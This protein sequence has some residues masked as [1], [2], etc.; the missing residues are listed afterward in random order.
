[1]N[2]KTKVVAAFA[3]AAFLLPG[4]SLAQTATATATGLRAEVQSL[5][6]E[7]QSL[8]SQIH[9]NPSRVCPAWGCNGPEPTPVPIR[10]PITIASSSTPTTTPTTTPAL[11]VSIDRSSPPAG[12]IVQNSTGNT[13]G[14][15]DFTNTSNSEG[16]KITQMNVLDAVANSGVKAAFSN[17]SLW[18]G[19]TEL[20]TAS[21][22][23][24][25]AAGTGYLYTFNAFPNAPVVP[26]NNSL[27]LTLRGDAGSYAN[28]SMT[29]GSTLTF[30]IATTTDLNNDTPALAVMAYGAT[31]NV[32]AA[33]TL[34]GADANPQTVLRTVL[35]IA[36]QTVT[37]MPPSSF[38]QLGSV[39]LTANAAGDAVLNSL[40]LTT[41]QTNSAFLSSLVLHDSSG[42]DIVS[43]DGFAQSAVSGNAVT[44]TFSPSAKPLDVA[45]GSAYTLTLW[46]DLSKL[47]AVANVAQ[48]ISVSIQNSTDFSYYD[49]AN[50]TPTLV[51]LGPYQ[52]GPITVVSLQGSGATSTPTSTPITKFPVACP[53][54]MPYCPNGWH[55]VTT[56][57]GCSMRA[58][59]SGS[60][61]IQPGRLQSSAGNT[62]DQTAI[63][64]QSLQT[65]GSEL[66]G[67]LK[68]L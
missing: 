19:S 67:L 21:A 7:V 55:T 63:I 38:Q 33:I 4:I 15:F 9:Q 40:K 65:I 62:G 2:I 49:G 32:V 29:D 54:L 36:G 18:N 44:W 31:S 43:V 30:K 3:A 61:G 11:S 58:C 12:I 66:E 48:S 35:T 45:A 60:V 28:G 59:N 17:V 57:N 1:M 26:R 24:L 34:S 50:G 37:T 22:P 68:S 64:S 53:E 39:N 52:V 27:Q 47:P 8:E 5:L 6:A 13:L 46:G 41:N 25:D 14:V 23:V 51:N 10:L 56:S 42:N 20:G 16:I